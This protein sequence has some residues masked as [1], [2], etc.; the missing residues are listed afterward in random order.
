MRRSQ[1]VATV[2]PDPIPPR[3]LPA[4]LSTQMRPAAAPDSPY[5]ALTGTDGNQP[6]A[7]ARGRSTPHAGA[8]GYSGEGRRPPPHLFA[9]HT[10]AHVYRVHDTASATRVNSKAARATASRTTSF[11]ELSKTW[12]HVSSA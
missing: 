12:K 4:T 6:A 3:V 8:C 5:C 11:D 1:R 10:S 2:R 7:R 9:G